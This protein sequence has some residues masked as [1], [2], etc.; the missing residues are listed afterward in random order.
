V[1]CSRRSSRMHRYRSRCC[2]E[3]PELVVQQDGC[4]INQ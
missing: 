4:Q 3:T 2:E 1:A